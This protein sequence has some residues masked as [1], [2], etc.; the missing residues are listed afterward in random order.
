MRADYFGGD[1]DRS[2]DGFDLGSRDSAG[3]EQDRL[4]SGER[5]HCRFNSHLAWTAI[6]DAIDVGT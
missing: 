3:S 5:E 6:E 1:G 4:Q 2:N